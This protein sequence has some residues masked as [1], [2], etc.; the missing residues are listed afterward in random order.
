MSGYD[1]DNDNDGGLREWA[2]TQEAKEIHWGQRDAEALRKHREWVQNF[3]R[4]LTTTNAKNADN[5]TK[6]EV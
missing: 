6:T 4:G 1:D 5:E 2:E 3:K